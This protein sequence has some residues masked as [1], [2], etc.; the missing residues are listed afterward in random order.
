ME[1][2]MGAAARGLNDYGFLGGAQ[3]DPYGNL[4][5]TV[6][7]DYV[8]PK[9][10]LPGSSGA[11]DIDTYCWRTIYPMRHDK[12]RFVEKLDFMTMPGYLTVQERE[13]GQACR[14]TPD[15]IE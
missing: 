13:R 15:R 9:V 14:R 7:G 1:N 10:R 6:I 4:N 12:M 8:Q 11:N 5:T 2:V 3:V